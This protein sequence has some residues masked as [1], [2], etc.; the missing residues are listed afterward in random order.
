MPKNLANA[1]LGLTPIMTFNQATAALAVQA[2]IDFLSEDKHEDDIGYHIDEMTPACQVQLLL[3]LTNLKTAM[4]TA[5]IGDTYASLLVNPSGDDNALLFTAKAPGV[6]GEA[7]GVVY[8]V[9]GNDTPLSVDLTEGL[10]T[11]N[12]ATDSGGAATSTAN[13]VLAALLAD[14][15]IA[16]IVDIELDDTDV[17]ND[18]TGVVAAFSED[19]LALA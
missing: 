13:A 2:L 9:A 11:V 4:G 3:E 1:F 7:I 19:N 17:D 6:I 16:A 10:I 18:G 8:V 15:D 12:V 5:P 14:A